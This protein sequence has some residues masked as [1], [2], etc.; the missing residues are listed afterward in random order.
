MEDLNELKAGQIVW[1]V[2]WERECVTGE[3]FMASC[4]DHAIVCPKQFGMDFESQ[5]S[6][7]SEKDGVDVRV[8][9]KSNVFKTREEAE[10]HL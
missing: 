1:F 10:K 9:H 3:L 6:Y 5:V 8:I 2:D 7:M 4:L